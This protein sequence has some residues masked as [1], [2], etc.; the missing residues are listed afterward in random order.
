MS[1]MEEDSNHPLSY[2]EILMEDLKHTQRL[3]EIEEVN[4]NNPV[5]KDSVNILH[6]IKNR[7]EH[8]RRAAKLIQEDIKNCQ[9]KIE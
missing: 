9:L 3:I 5:F 6:N 1:D 2:K 8:L 7:L 4:L